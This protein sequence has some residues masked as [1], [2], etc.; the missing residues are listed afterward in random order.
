MSAAASV[1]NSQTKMGS[2]VK[3]NFT[4][5]GV[6]TPERILVRF[7]VAIGLSGVVIQAKLGDDRFSHLVAF[8]G[9]SNFILTYEVVLMTLS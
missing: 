6:K 2:Q 3:S 7:C 5:M 9:W 4:Y 1:K 8:G